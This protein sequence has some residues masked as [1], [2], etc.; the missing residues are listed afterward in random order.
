MLQCPSLRH[1]LLS[2]SISPASVLHSGKTLYKAQGSSCIPVLHTS[3]PGLLPSFIFSCGLRSSL[4]SKRDSTS[5]FSLTGLLQGPSAAQ[6]CHLHVS[7]LFL[8]HL[9][10][11]FSHLPTPKLKIHLATVH[12]LEQLP[13]HLTAPG[14]IRTGLAPNSSSS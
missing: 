12:P 14:R 6:R 1:V 7:N 8:G 9:T 11:P 3:S 5:D 10:N 4:F 2:I 13:F